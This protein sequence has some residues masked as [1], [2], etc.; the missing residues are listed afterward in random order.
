MNIYNYY[1]EIH[2]TKYIY[3]V[4]MVYYVCMYIYTVYSGNIERDL[5]EQLS[6]RSFA[7]KYTDLAPNGKM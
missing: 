6:H 4:N 7:A 2:G 1:H 3:F 5:T